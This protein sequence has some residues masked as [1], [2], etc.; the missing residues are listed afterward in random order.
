MSIAKQWLV[1]EA[2]SICLEKHSSLN[3]YR[4]RQ[5]IKSVCKE[6]QRLLP[7]HQRKTTIVPVPET[8]G[9]DV[10][11][12]Q[13]KVEQFA[14]CSG[15]SFAV[16]GNG[17][18]LLRKVD[19]NAEPWC[20]ILVLPGAQLKQEWIESSIAFNRTDMIFCFELDEEI[21]SENDTIVQIEASVDH[22]IIKIIDDEK[23]V[24]H[25]YRYFA[26]TRRRCKKRLDASMIL[27]Y[28][29]G[30]LMNMGT[31][32]GKDQLLVSPDYV[33]IANDE[34]LI[35]T[36]GDKV[37]PAHNV[38]TLDLP[39]RNDYS[40]KWIKSNDVLA[41]YCDTTLK[42]IVKIPSKTNV[43]YWVEIPPVVTKME[44][45]KPMYM[46][47]KKEATKWPELSALFTACP[48]AIHLLSKR[49]KG[50]GW[51]R[52]HWPATA[53]VSTATNQTKVFDGPVDSDMV[54]S[55]DV[56][57]VD[58]VTTSIAKVER[59]DET[60]DMDKRMVIKGDLETA[61]HLNGKTLFQL[62]HSVNGSS[63]D[64]MFDWENDVI[65]YKQV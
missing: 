47:N 10:M 52:P 24:T 53:F 33:I 31:E 29:T 41:I 28:Q 34:V 62:S 19:E 30:Q 14:T 6:W 37:E 60:C 36:F 51:S 12:Y 11:G 21:H 17:K 61:V 15:K 1:H 49:L 25:L 50:C 4:N 23:P 45:F 7:K 54:V 43:G 57:T 26:G 59:A 58:I 13:W 42:H 8:A 40:V 27:P 39:Q 20:P 3:S 22:V 35:K 48:S 5:I 16:V 56:S 32:K 63:R 38:V 18:V 55:R 9:N 46:W 64:Y 65:F 44:D 2:F